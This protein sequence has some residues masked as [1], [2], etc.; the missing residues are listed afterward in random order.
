MLA[1]FSSDGQQ[2]SVYNCKERTKTTCISGFCHRILVSFCGTLRRKVPHLLPPSPQSETRNHLTPYY[3]YYN[4]VIAGQ[5]ILWTMGSTNRQAI[6][7]RRP[8]NDS[9]NH[10]YRQRREG[11]LFLPTSCT[12][13]AAARW[14][15]SS[16]FQNP[17]SR[18]LICKSNS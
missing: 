1:G 4:V 10:G 6:W 16:L 5:I 3:Y 9:C 12:L 13:E 11:A 18:M 2:S 14:W 17:S 7:Q 8:S 15:E